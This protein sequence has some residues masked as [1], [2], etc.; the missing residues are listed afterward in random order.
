MLT[1]AHKVY[2]HAWIVSKSQAI[3]RHDDYADQSFL[4]GISM[5]L[6]DIIR[7]RL[8]QINMACYL[9]GAMYFKLIWK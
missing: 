5:D 2:T 7:C 3:E 4:Y 6:Q 1:C 9:Q 8:C